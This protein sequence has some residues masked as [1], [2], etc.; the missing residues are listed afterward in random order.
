MKSV[1]SVTLFFSFSFLRLPLVL[2]NGGVSVSVGSV[3]VTGLKTKKP[4]MTPRKSS[5]ACRPLV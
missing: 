1:T 4:E 2:A 3:I 5:A